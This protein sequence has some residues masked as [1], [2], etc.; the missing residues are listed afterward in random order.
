MVGTTPGTNIIEY[1]FP[2][3]ADVIATLFLPADLTLSEV[4][5]LRRYMESLM[6]EEVPSE[7]S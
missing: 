2:L 5:R 7:V 3:R 4:E 6:T 1:E